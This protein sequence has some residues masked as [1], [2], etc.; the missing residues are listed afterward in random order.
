MTLSD[1]RVMEINIIFDAVNTFPRKTSKIAFIVNFNF[2]L[3]QKIHHLR[4]RSAR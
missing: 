4:Q 2:I 3:C 1:D